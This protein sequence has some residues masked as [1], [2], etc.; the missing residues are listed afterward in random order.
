MKSIILFLCVLLISFSAYA[1]ETFV[2]TSKDEVKIDLVKHVY[3]LETE[4][5]FWSGSNFSFSELAEANWQ[6]SLKNQRSYIRG[7]WLKLVVFNKTNYTYFGLGHE[8]LD[9]SI[10][11]TEV[12]NNVEKNTYIHK[13]TSILD[14]LTGQDFYDN[15]QIRIPH[16]SSAN[17]YTWIQTDNFNRWY[18]ITRPY[19]QI[20]LTEWAQL[21]KDVLF[22]IGTKAA[23]VI[24]AWTFTLYFIITLL[25]NFRQVNLFLFTITA[26]TASLYTFGEI[27]IGYLIHMPKMFTISNLYAI[28]V[29]T[30]ILAYNQ[31]VYMMIQ[32][33]RFYPILK[34][35][36]IGTQSVTT[37]AL[38]ANIILLFFFPTKFETDLIKYPLF[39]IPLGPSF[40]PPLS[41][42]IF[43]VIQ[44]VPLIVFAAI[45][46]KHGKVY[47]ISLLTSMVFLLLIPLKYILIL[48]FNVPFDALPSSEFLLGGLICLLGVTATL[49]IRQTE[50]EQL[51]DQL[52]LKESYARFVP[53]ELNLLLNK[54]RITDVT[55]GDQKEYDMS[56]LFT[57]IRGFTTIS[58]KMTPEENFK[59]INDF[60]VHM[61][62]IVRENNGFVNKFIGDSIMAIFHNDITDAVQCSIEMIK[63]L[64]LFNNYL[65]DSAYD[66]IKIGVGVNSGKLML[67]TLGTHDRMEASVIGDAVNLASRLE[68]LT[69][70]YNCPV[71]LS[72]HTVQ[73]LPE[74]RYRLRMID[75]VAVKGKEEKTDIFQLLDVYTEPMIELKQRLLPL[76]DRAYDA[77]MNEEFIRADLMF[78][79]IIA[80]DPSDHIAKLYIERCEDEGEHMS[81]ER[82]RIFFL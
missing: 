77:F 59:F 72:G 50:A 45:S 78:K 60:L 58:E 16:N 14:S 44:L 73:K 22:T 71:L 20:Y 65:I 31:F 55:L 57:D 36:Q 68:A 40:V 10:V 80:E 33:E 39:D 25:I 42:I 82:R 66:P 38:F 62:P 19:E 51:T 63:K 4:Q 5:R 48:R 26:A 61:T 21:Q 18:G 46:T 35:I 52:K 27:G 8:N 30:G 67:G 47:S 56:I 41:I 74:S 81:A 6:D 79:E 13:E 34:K 37:A 7:F 43:W 29:A 69:K 75:S 54:K 24:F 53:E 64:Q 49:K 17:I 12:R 23:F 2:L 9:Q 32:G 11:Y 76:F 1:K 15:M 3:F 28:V 70:Y